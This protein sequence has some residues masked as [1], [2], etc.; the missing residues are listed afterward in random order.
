MTKHLLTTYGTLVK[1]TTSMNTIPTTSMNT[2]TLVSS[3]MLQH[4]VLLHQSA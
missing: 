4:F 3:F 2:A 1:Q